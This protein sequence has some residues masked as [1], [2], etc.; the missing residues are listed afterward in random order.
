MGE[1]GLR[2]PFLIRSPEGD[3]FFLIATDLSIGRN[4]DWDRSQRT[5]SKYLEVWESTDLV[6]WSAQR[7]VK[8]SPDTAGNTWA[9]EAYWDADLGQYVVFWASKLYAETDTNHTGSTYNRMLYATTRDFRT[10]SEPRIWQDRGESRIDSTVIKENGTYYRFTKDE[11]GGGTGCSDIIQEKAA[12]LTAVDLPGNPAWTFMKGCIGREAGTSAVEGPTVFKANPGDTSGS[13][14]LPLRR[15]VRRPRLHPA[16]H[17]RPREPELA[18]ARR[19]QPARQPAP[20]HR[21][22]GDP[23]R[24]RPR[25][26]LGGPEPPAPVE[27]DENGL[28]A[29]YPLTSA[30]PRRPTQR[31]RLRRHRQRGRVAGP[32]ARSTLGGTNGHVKLPDNMMTGLDA[33]TVSTGGVGRPEPADA[34]LHLGPG[35]H[36]R[37]RD[38]QRLPVHHRQQLPGLDRRRQLDDRADRRDLQRAAPRGVEDAD[39]HAG[40]RAPPRSTSTACRSAQKTGVTIDP[41]DIGGGRTTAN[42]IGRSVYAGDKYLK[43]KVRDFRHLQPGAVGR[44]GRRSSAPTRPRS[45]ASSWT[46]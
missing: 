26:G 24:A 22:P 42:Y 33:I 3:R 37:G 12:S 19:L 35:Q 17:R 7:H 15:R 25:C 14:V 41:G 28:V 31:P 16:R 2:D 21:H 1:M 5:G 6:T 29:H 13:Q 27:A 8:V 23:G 45:S 4:G 44:R 30:A 36:R 39:L 40:R 46:A 9:P 11:G 32:T 18:R 10:F 38:R 34:V 43:G 20:R